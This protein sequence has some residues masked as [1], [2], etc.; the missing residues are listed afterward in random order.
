[1]GLYKPRLK[2]ENYSEISSII[3]TFLAFFVPKAGEKS[4]LLNCQGE[5][6]TERQ[7]EEVLQTIVAHSPKKNGILGTFFRTKFG[8]I[9]KFEKIL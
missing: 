1:M 7:C 5:V 4:G 8:K 9:L 2:K 3:A 6:E